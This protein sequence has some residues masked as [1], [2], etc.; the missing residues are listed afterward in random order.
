MA[1]MSHTT[2]ARRALA[3]MAVLALALMGLLVGSNQ[4]GDGSY[5]PKLGLDLEGGTQIILEPR[6]TGNREVSP[7][8]IAQAR[9]IIVQRVDAGGVA[10]AEVTTQGGRN[11]V[12]SMPG[13]PSKSTEDAIRR[14]SQLQFRPV[15]AIAA[16]SPQPAPTGSASP[17]PSA[18][19]SPGASGTAT[20][21]GRP[22]S[23]STST[24]APSWCS[25]RC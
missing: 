24:G 20:P 12:V 4:F 21:S 13:T 9:D 18:P 7:E 2:F 22:S 6:V 19:A 10:G 5:A 11:I 1:Q 17:S 15:L 14:S 8:Q 3:G 25:S 23:G 16:G